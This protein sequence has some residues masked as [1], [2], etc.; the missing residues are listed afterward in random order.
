MSVEIKG[1][2][3]KSIC[4]HRLKIVL[5]WK[6][7]LHNENAC[8]I[9]PIIKSIFN[10]AY[11]NSPVENSKYYANSISAVDL[12]IYCIDGV[13]Y[14]DPSRILNIERW[15]PNFR[16]V[17]ILFCSNLVGFNFE[18]FLSRKVSKCWTQFNFFNIHTIHLIENNFQLKLGTFH[19]FIKR[20]RWISFTFCNISG[21]IRINSHL[22]RNH[23][24]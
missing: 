17:E 13:T 18:H 2:A 11:Y 16:G 20:L 8:Y 10:S 12:F 6:N 23:L 15:A 3:V 24:G 19:L 14:Y 9:N 21:L 7:M 4:F 5:Y 1:Q 22:A